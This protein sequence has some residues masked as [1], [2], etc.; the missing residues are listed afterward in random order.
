MR[1]A[2]CFLSS[3]RFVPVALF[4]LSIGMLATVPEI[5]MRR[6]IQLPHFPLSFFAFAVKVSTVAVLVV[7][8]VTNQGVP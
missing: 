8:S 6:I 4:S 5:A 7:C 1:S 3:L 2:G